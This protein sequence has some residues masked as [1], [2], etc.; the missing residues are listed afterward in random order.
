MLFR[1]LALVVFVLVVALIGLPAVYAPPI[2]PRQ[3]YITPPKVIP[4]D[5]DAPVVSILCPSEAALEMHDI[6][7]NL[8]VTKPTSWNNDSITFANYT[9]YSGLVFNVTYVLDGQSTEE[10]IS[11]SD[12]WTSKAAMHFGLNLTN[13]ANGPH[14]IVVNASAW[15]LFAPEIYSFRFWNY[16]EGTSGMFNFTVNVPPEVSILSPE[17]LVYNESS[18]TFTFTANEAISS[19][20]FS[21]DNQENQ[22]VSTNVTLADLA[23]G[24]HTLQAYAQVPTGGVGASEVVNFTVD[25]PPTIKIL[26][27]VNEPYNGTDIPVSF[28]D[29][30]PILWA[31]YSLDGQDYVSINGN[32]TLDNLSDGSHM[33]IVYAADVYGNVGNSGFVTF[34]KYPVMAPAPSPTT[35]YEDILNN[36]TILVGATSV[37]VVL[38]AFC[39]VLFRKKHRMPL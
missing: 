39:V 21:I 9:E 20:W 30:K 32:T 10:S 37:I 29:N 8:T 18:V 5:N 17:N 11:T 24:K 7:L 19:S 2:F 1:S 34:A 23:E 15:S 38:V 25:L 36:S 12:N 22:T 14:S 6:I 28:T 13:L 4:Y 26:L 33:L 16:V 31:A 3:V 27:P 35:V